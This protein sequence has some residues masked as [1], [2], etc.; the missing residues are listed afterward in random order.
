MY[1]CYHSSE[2]ANN[3]LYI[4]GGVTSLVSNATFTGNFFSLDLIISPFDM[5]YEK[6]L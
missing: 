2:I 3:K 5:P 1:N 6:F 4:G